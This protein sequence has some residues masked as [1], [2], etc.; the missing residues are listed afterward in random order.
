MISRTLPLL[1]LFAGVDA[2]GQ[3][4]AGPA[5]RL[6]KDPR[7]ILA[8]AAPYYD[9]SDPAQKPWHLKASYQLYDD[10]GNPTT[11]GIYEYWWTSPAVYRSTWTRIAATHSVWHTKDGKEQFTSS[12]DPLDYFE[13]QL[14]SELLAPLPSV[15]SL[16]KSKQRV[17]HGEIKVGGDKFPCVYRPG[18]GLE[19]FQR[20]G[21]CFDPVY[22]VL[23]ITFSGEG[24][25]T[26]TFDSIRLFQGKYLA[27]DILT[28]VG[29]RRLFSAKVESTDPLA[30]SDFNLIPP[31][32][33]VST[34]DSI[35][36]PEQPG[37]K[38]LLKKQFPIYPQEAKEKR[39]Q[40][41]VLVE[42]TIGKD[43]KIKKQRVLYSPS[44]LLTASATESLWHWEYKPFLVNGEPVQV[45]TL[46][47][48]IY[49]LRQ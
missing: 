13:L 37:S 40:G 26:T 10:Q 15:E 11:Q 24:T 8:A 47:H 7:A 22:P 29:N 44:R 33:A 36:V 9:F 16:D 25:L 41:I 35:L 14:K 45:E 2:L 5:P 23:R 21:Y 27:G 20:P 18:N 6:P 42:A 38:T 34:P 43:G 3:K 28:R 48:V 4:P 49:T 46:I 12:G 19:D 30:A 17:S 31:K 1:L 32:D 39:I